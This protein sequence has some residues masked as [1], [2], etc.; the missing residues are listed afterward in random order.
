MRRSTIFFVVIVL[1]RN[2]APNIYPVTGAPHCLGVT[3]RLS[4]HLT[5]NSEPS[6]RSVVGGREASPVFVPGLRGWGLPAPGCLKSESEERETWTAESLRA[7][8]KD[9]LRHGRGCGQVENTSAVYVS[10]YIATGR[11]TGQVDG[12]RQ[13][14]RRASDT[15][16]TCDQPRSNLMKLESLILAQSERWRQA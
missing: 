3:S 1:T 15:S 11:A 7:A 12:P 8:S 4:K 2:R 10:R 6:F 9:M 5:R 14:W 16:E 13:R